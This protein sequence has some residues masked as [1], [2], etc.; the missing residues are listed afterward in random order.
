VPQSLG[1][2]ARNPPL[3]ECAVGFYG[4]IPSRGDFVRSGLPHGFIDPWDRWMQ[5]GIAASHA[6][7]GDDWVG[8]WLRAAIWSFALAPGLCGPDAVLGLWLPS[9]DRVGRHFSLTLA[10]VVP[11]GQLLQ[12][13][14]DNGGF[15]GAVEH[16]GLAALESNISPDELAALSRAAV[17]AEPIDPG[18]DPAQYPDARA[19]WWT[20][21]APRVP[22]QAF[23]SD[24]LPDAAAFVKMLD[25]HDPVDIV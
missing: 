8:V 20:E 2:A 16:A 14:H 12:L 15:L 9:V 25:G 3:R 11:G 24:A 6:A 10:A 21:G 4:K 18:I 17:N 13:V 23:A 5:E 1:A 22:R 19:L 7:L